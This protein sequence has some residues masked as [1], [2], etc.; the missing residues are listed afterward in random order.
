LS[1][2]AARHSGPTAI[3]QGAIA[4]SYAGLERA[5]GLVAGLALAATTSD[6]SDRRG[7]GQP[8][9]LEDRAVNRGIYPREIEEVLH[10]HPDVLEDAVIGFPLNALGE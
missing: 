6:R 8:I 9:S 7:L 10:E 2:S 5:T 4:L 1:A 3:R